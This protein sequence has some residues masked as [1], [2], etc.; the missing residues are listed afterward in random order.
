MNVT[1]AIRNPVQYE[2]DPAT[3]LKTKY[4]V[5]GLDQSFTHVSTNSD[6]PFDVM[7]D[8]RNVW[9]H[10][11]DEPPAGLDCPTDPVL[12]DLLRKDMGCGPIPE[13]WEYVSNGN[14]VLVPLADNV[15]IG[16]I[17]DVTDVPADEPAPDGGQA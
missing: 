3:G 13:D 6:N 4:R 1:L 5:H 2:S 10:C 11:S 17:T 15:A 14:H 7:R 12:E 9:P 8:L 16:V